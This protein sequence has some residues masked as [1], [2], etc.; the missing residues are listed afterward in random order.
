MYPFGSIWVGTQVERLPGSRLVAS[1][2]TFAPGDVKTWK[3]VVR[4]KAAQ[5][6]IAGSQDMESRVRDV[7]FLARD[8][9]LA[10]QHR[11]R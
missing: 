6:S 5:C 10:G 11:E 4:V 2:L 3:E 1:R 7:V 9:S 8:Q